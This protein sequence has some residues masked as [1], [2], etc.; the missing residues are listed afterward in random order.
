[1]STESDQHASS[2][3]TRADWDE[4]IAHRRKV[5]DQAR[6]EFRQAL[7]RSRRALAEADAALRIGPR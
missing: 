5:M 7:R 2:R 6:S 1:M 3:L 4:R